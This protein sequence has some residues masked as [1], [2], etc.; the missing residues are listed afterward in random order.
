MRT[1]KNKKRFTK[2]K[3]RITKN[4]KRINGGENTKKD[5]NINNNVTLNNFRAK[6]IRCSP[7]VLN[8]LNMFSCYTD[9]SLFKLRDLWNT[10]HP[11]SP[12]KSNNGKEIHQLLSKYMNNVCETEACWLNQNFINSKDVKNIESESFAPEQPDEWDKKPNEWLTSMDIIKV[13]KQYEKAYKCFQFIGPTPIDFDKKMAF[14]ECVWEELC[15]FNIEN[16]IKNGKFKIGIV[17]NTDTHDK[18]GQHWISMFINIKKAQ[19]FFFDSVGDKATPEI[20]KFVERVKEQGAKLN[21]KFEYDENHPV[22]HQYGNTECGI[23]SIFFIVHMLQDKITEDYLKSHI[24][25]DKYMS[26]FRA[27]YFNK[28]A[29]K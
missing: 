23:Y 7:K 13:M 22:E 19:I 14:G 26:E 6:K 24:L 28:T 18:S 5:K 16:Q 29:K 4:K 10:K 27:K 8:E 21:I 20:K 11:D 25:K 17:F 3:K 2:N 1:Q 15:N 12:I 9:K